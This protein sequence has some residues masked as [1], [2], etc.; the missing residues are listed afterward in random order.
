LRPRL[1]T[2]LPFSVARTR[3]PL[4]TGAFPE[5]LCYACTI[6]CLL[7]PRY[8]SW[9]P[10]LYIWKMPCVLDLAEKGE[11]PEHHCGV[12]DRTYGELP[13]ITNELETLSRRSTDI[14]QRQAYSQR[15]GVLTV[16]ARVERTSRNHWTSDGRLV[17]RQCRHSFEGQCH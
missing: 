10:S 11:G 9:R 7:A 12:A 17:L 15:R 14:T 1:T 5:C 6:H 3:M 4:A 16:P 2:G 13:I 8:M